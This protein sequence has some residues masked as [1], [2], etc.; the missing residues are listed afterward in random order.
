[1]EWIC[2]LVDLSICQCAKDLRNHLGERKEDFVFV[3]GEEIS[4]LANK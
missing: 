4:K 1:M 2:R 3:I